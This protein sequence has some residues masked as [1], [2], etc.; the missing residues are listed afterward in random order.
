M[1]AKR[2]WRAVSRAEDVI[3]ELRAQGSPENVAGMARFGIR[4]ANALGVSMVTLRKTARRLGRDHALARD[5]WASGVHE[6][7]ILAAL[8][9]EPE[10][11]TSAQM[12]RWMRAFDSWDVCDQVCANLFDRT[13]FA[14]EKAVAWS[15][16]EPEF[17]RRAGFA[18][19]ASLARH[20]KDAP[21]A[22]FRAFFPAIRAGATDERNYVWKA[23]SWAL[24]E[25]GKRGGALQAAA[26]KE[27][28]A[29]VALPDRTARRIGREALREL[30]QGREAS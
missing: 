18:L 12:D 17:E 6:A 28:E 27:A 29:L 16:R 1:R 8:V 24:R 26:V 20:A 10:R 22:R 15:R 23:V 11:V 25:V 4:P 9:D 3:A 30:R 13:P 5:L 19:M 7:R 2:R 14:W 21:D